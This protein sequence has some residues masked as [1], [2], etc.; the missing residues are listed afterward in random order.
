MDIKIP[1]HVEYIL[2]KLEKNGYDAYIVGGCIRDT[3]LNKIPG[4]FDVT[5]NALPEEIEVVFNDKKTIDVGKKYGTMIVNIDKDDVEITTFRTE[6]DYVDGRRPEWVEFVSSIEKD[7][8]RRDFTINAMAYNKKK[9]LVDPFNGVKDI[10]ERIIRCVGDPEERFHEDYLRILRAI[11]FSSVLDFQIE[12]DTFLAGKKYSKYVSKVSM[13]RINKELVKILLCDTPSKGIRLLEEVEL[14]PI[15][16]P[17]FVP[18]IGFDQHNPHH[19]KDV[20]GHTL[21]VLDKIPANLKLRLAALFH[22]VGKPS[23]FSI[24]E[25]GIGHFYDHN[26]VGAKISESALERLKYPKELSK[27]V[28]ILVRE[29]MTHHSNF[30]D[31]GLKRLIRRV[32]VENIDDLFILQK[33]DRSC[34]NKDASIENIIQTELRVKEILDKNEAYE[35]RQLN[36]N[37]HDLIGVGYKEGEIIGEILEYILSRVIA[38]P[39]LNQRDKLIKIV[40]KKFPLNHTNED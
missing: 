12:E 16:L 17:E 6:G 15:I 1:D 39:S 32:G 28:S 24:D 36:I 18:S 10:N 27:N 2:T 21:C 25:K 19:D 33:A 4:D 13:E 38:N 14:I 8:S 3:L 11:R 34:S 20:F 31:K 29:H 22:D 40:L 37:G 7:L 5:T 26:K 9:G 30:S 35:I 23:C